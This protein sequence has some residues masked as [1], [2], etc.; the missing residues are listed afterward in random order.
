MTREEIKEIKGAIE[1][2]DDI[3]L[4]V[5]IQ[6]CKELHCQ[7][8]QMC[9]WDRDAIMDVIEKVLEGDKQ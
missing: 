7:S 3:V 9:F 2:L 6:C 4:D 1:E 8:I 5:I